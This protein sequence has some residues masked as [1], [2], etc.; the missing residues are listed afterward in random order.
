MKNTV[1]L[2]REYIDIYLSLGTKCGVGKCCWKMERFFLFLRKAHLR[3]YG[4][5]YPNEF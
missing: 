2:L 4:Y 5:P 1:K 3:Y